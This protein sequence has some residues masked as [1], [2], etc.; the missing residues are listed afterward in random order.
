MKSTAQDET[1]GKED[2]SVKVAKAAAFAGGL[3]FLL[4]SLWV[5]GGPERRL[6]EWLYDDSFYY[7]ITAKHW[8]EQRLASF[9]GITVTSGYHPLWMWLCAVIYGVRTRL[10]LTYVRLCMTLSF[11]LTVCAFLLW[12][13]MAT[14]RRDSG[15][16]W[17]LA[18]GA[19]SYSALN[20]GLTVMEW[21]LVILSWVLLHSLLLSAI[22]RRE[23][24]YVVGA[25]YVAAFAVG[26]LGSLSRTDFG[27]IPASYVVGAVVV[28]RRYGDWRVAK[29]AL[30]ALVGSV[31]GL[32]TVFL[33]YHATTGS[34][35]QKSAE[36]KQAVAAL[37][38]PFNPVPPLWQFLR[39]LFYLPALEVGFESKAM[40][41]RVGLKVLVG[42]LLVG[43]VLVAARWRAIRPTAK[44]I[45]K[46]S[47]EDDFA[48]VSGTV[49]IVG[50]LLVYSLNSQATYGWYSAT[51]TGFILILAARLLGSM[52]WQIAMSFVLP[53]MLLNLIT[54]S[55]F[56]GNARFQ[57]QENAM[58][59]RMRAEHPQVRM[60][61]GD[62]GK[63]SFYNNGTMVN[64]D[65]LMNN[66]VFPY[67]VTGR[68]HCYILQEHIEYLSDVGSITLPLTDGE[69]ARRHEAPLPWTQ[70][71]IPVP[72]DYAK[73]D[74]SR[75]LQ[76]DFDAIRR[77]GECSKD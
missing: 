44:L 5:I 15:A 64:L 6:M 11:G 54:A 59:K 26:A 27:L 76:T 4:H 75:Y 66:E 36:V 53:I 12:A 55:V 38:S 21:P 67:L 10:D 77:S 48:L 45:F 9:D 61:G 37:S 34:W 14:G 50:Y 29:Q 62:V 69:R 3:Y 72:K 31:I 40:L 60:G 18:L 32:A 47:A 58:G 57:W 46:R 51:V 24:E 22:E 71:F 52:R 43:I 7:L 2:L 25:M 35:L 20:N 23:E 16:L 70:Y 28:T 73:D 68:I 17:A 42:L 8:S 49:G 13:R 56:G 19:T 63:P 1:I 33:Y 41:L 30:T 65:G 74:S 39:V